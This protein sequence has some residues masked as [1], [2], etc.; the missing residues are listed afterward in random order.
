MRRARTSHLVPG[1]SAAR[2]L[3]L[4]ALAAVLAGC[5]IQLVPK[6]DPAIVNGLTA[7]NEKTLQ[8][9]A[10]L[11]EPGT[12]APY[13]EREA[14]YNELI[15]SFDSLRIQAAARPVPD[16]RIAE[17]LVSGSAANLAPEDIKRLQNPNPDIL[18]TII[19]TLTRMREVDSQGRLSAGMLPG[20]KTS[21]ET[22]IDQALTFEQALAQ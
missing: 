13:A 20:F 19:D 12:R 11:A 17:T 7:A 9:F 3:A 4:L 16:S 18:Q 10:A 21:Y 2:L 8:L 14:T 1:R 5:Q 15:G 6:P 22:S